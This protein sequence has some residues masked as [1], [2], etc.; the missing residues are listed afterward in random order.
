MPSS[1]VIPVLSVVTITA[2]LAW[3]IKKHLAARNGRVLAIY[4]DARRLLRD[5]LAT[6]DQFVEKLRSLR[7]GLELINVDPDLRLPTAWTAEGLLDH[8][9]VERF[10]AVDD[11][12]RIL[13]DN[14]RPVNYWCGPKMDLEFPHA[15]WSRSFLQECRQPSKPGPITISV[16]IGFLDRCLRHFGVTESHAGYDSTD[17]G[18]LVRKNFMKRLLRGQ[19]DGSTYSSQ[20]AKSPDSTSMIEDGPRLQ[21]LSDQQVGRLADLMDSRMTSLLSGHLYLADGQ[22][23]PN[24]MGA[25]LFDMGLMIH[26]L[27]AYLVDRS[28]ARHYITPV[29]REVLLRHDCDD[30]A[31]DIAISKVQQL[32]D[33]FEGVIAE[34]ENPLASIM[35]LGAVAAF[36]LM[37]DEGLDDTTRIAAEMM[38]DALRLSGSIRSILG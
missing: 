9:M 21:E 14:G 29:A 10:H 24:T 17:D 7:R 3:L 30:Y 6:P 33:T 26:F 5:D 16:A 13:E 8:F 18:D 2:M 25:L 1:I 22:T 31:I 27:S 38:D 20:D 11:Y 15:D 36:G 19:F 28:G 12:R 23:P 35:A 37:L 4:N 34:D 32:L